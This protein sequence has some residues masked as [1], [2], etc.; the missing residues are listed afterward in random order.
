ML[1]GGSVFEAVR[2]NHEESVSFMEDFVNRRF[3]ISILQSLEVSTGF[4]T[5]IKL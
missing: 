3:P 1:I 4:R 5:A 2:V